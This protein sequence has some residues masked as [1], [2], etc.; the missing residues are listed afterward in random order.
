MVLSIP[1]LNTQYPIPDGIFQH[2]ETI[3]FCVTR[4]LL[5]GPSILDV[6]EVGKCF[7]TSE[8]V[9]FWQ[10]GHQSPLGVFEWLRARSMNN[11]QV[12]L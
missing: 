11:I 6:F 4:V 5:G 9:S 2:V 8:C 3:Q 12:R 10:L 1:I 7:S